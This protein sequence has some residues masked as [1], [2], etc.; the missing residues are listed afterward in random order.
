M[1]VFYFLVIKPASK[2][3]RIPKNDIQNQKNSTD[4][5]VCQNS[6]EENIANEKKLRQQLSENLHLDDILKENPLQSPNESHFALTPIAQSK[7]HSPAN[8][9]TSVDCSN[10]LC[11]ELDQLEKQVSDSDNALSD[12]LNSEE[13]WDI[14]WTPECDKSQLDTVDNLLSPMDEN[15]SMFAQLP[16]ADSNAARLDNVSNVTIKDTIEICDS[17]SF[18][19]EVNFCFILYV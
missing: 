1:Y 10:I 15:I 5:N 12:A 16:S 19:K 4:E 9:F 2:V 8:G 13:K 14:D 6:D 18:K 3:V 11:Q 7:T 17:K